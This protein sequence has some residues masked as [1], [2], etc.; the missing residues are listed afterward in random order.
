MDRWVFRVPA[1]ESPDGAGDTHYTHYVALTS[2][3]N[4]SSIRV[5]QPSHPSPI[6]AQAVTEDYHDSLRHPPDVA[7]RQ[8]RHPWQRPR[9]RIHQLNLGCGLFCRLRQ[10]VLEFSSNTGASTKSRGETHD[11]SART[12]PGGK[13][14]Y[15]TT[16]MTARNARPP[17]ASARRDGAPLAAATAAWSC[18]GAAAVATPA[19]MARHAQ[20]RKTPLAIRFY[21]DHR[22]L[23]ASLGKRDPHQMELCWGH[24]RVG[25]A[26]S[27]GMSP[28]RQLGFGDGETAFGD[29][30]K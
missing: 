24:S 1:T 16:P 26:Q 25:E 7:A 28:S 6:V 19:S 23:R 18:E 29:A 8:K 2:G 14:I 17:R 30:R 27:N 20:L 10:C 5:I 22:L 9:H 15:L 13:R 12:V 21:R 11:A 3:L 4:R